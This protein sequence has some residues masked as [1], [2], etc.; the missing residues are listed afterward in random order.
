[1]YIS[2]WYVCLFYLICYIFLL[3]VVVGDLCF[4]RWVFSEFESE[5]IVISY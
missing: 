1:M 4:L 5:V 2:I 3:E